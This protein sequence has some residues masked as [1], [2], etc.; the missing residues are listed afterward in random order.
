M[1][2][3]AGKEK[4][5]S[6]PT[7]GLICTK[8]LKIKRGL[9][10]VDQLSLDYNYKRSRKDISILA[11]KESMLCFLLWR[12][13]RQA[14]GH[15]LKILFKTVHLYKKGF[16]LQDFASHEH[17]V[18]PMYRVTIIFLKLSSTTKVYMPLGCFTLHK[19][20]T[21]KLDSCYF[22]ILHRYQI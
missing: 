5:I 7:N 18:K 21:V 4:G 15:H 14:I 12:L 6:G 19:T 2:K 3:C 22:T 20:W 13:I 17:S 8:I 16:S 11:L 10:L 1:S 9:S